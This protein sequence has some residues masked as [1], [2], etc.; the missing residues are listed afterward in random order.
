MPR[1]IGWNTGKARRFKAERHGKGEHLD[2][3]ESGIDRLVSQGSLGS[4]N[5][6][7]LCAC[8]RMCVIRSTYIGGLRDVEKASHHRRK[9]R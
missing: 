4:A 8:V 5:L 2:G 9:T 7:R 3:W 1:S 6:G